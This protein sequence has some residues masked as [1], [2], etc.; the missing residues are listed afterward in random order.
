MQNE[1]V[2]SFEGSF[3]L[4]YTDSMKLDCLFR[5]VLKDSK[6]NEITLREKNRK[7]GRT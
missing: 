6:K 2:E 4:H 7:L 5:P 3:F 1:L